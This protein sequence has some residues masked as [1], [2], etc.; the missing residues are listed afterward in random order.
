MS[1]S[2]LFTLS[3][4]LDRSGSVAGAVALLHVQTEDTQHQ[5][6]ANQAAKP[7]NGADTRSLLTPP[8]IKHE[9]NLPLCLASAIPG[10][11]R[12]GKA[13]DPS[14]KPSGAFIGSR[15]VGGLC[16][17]VLGVVSDILQRKPSKYSP[18]FPHSNR[19][20]GFCSE[21]PL[22]YSRRVIWG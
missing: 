4:I 20:H 14:H 13:S 2:Y 6:L 1:T 7:V 10:L 11:M 17:D 12:A 9:S 18:F 22:M 21:A 8:V 19:R 5:P 15:G 16:G 3:V